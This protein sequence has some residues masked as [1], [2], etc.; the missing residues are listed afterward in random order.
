MTPAGTPYPAFTQ[1]PLLPLKLLVAVLEEVTAG[2]EH[3]PDDA[4]RAAFQ[5]RATQA[6]EA[7]QACRRIAFS[8]WMHRALVAKVLLLERDVVAALRNRR[9]PLRAPGG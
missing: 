3:F 6:R 1:S 9:R 5:E 2:L 4:Q 7:I 8:Q